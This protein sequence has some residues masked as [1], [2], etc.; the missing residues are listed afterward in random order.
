MQPPRWPP[1]S[2]PTRCPPTSGS[3]SARLEPNRKSNPQTTTAMTAENWTKNSN[4]P[5]LFSIRNPTTLK[6]MCVCVCGLILGDNYISIE[7]ILVAGL[8][9]FKKYVSQILWLKK[10]PPKQKKI[11]TTY[12]MASFFV[13]NPKIYI[14]PSFFGVELHKIAARA[15]LVLAPP[16]HTKLTCEALALGK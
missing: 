15:S 2:R 14:N 7:S 6:K 5:W 1:P 11:E 4:V 16:F 3:F 9:P 10:D 12:P 13:A 8:N